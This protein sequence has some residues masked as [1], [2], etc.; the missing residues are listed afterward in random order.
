[1]PRKNTRNYTFYH[2]QE[3]LSE[4]P[5]IAPLSKKH[6]LYLNDETNDI[7]VFGGAAGSGKSQLSLM[8]ILQAALYDSDYVA[9]ILRKSQRMVKGAGSLWETGNKLFKPHG[10]TSNSIEMNW[11]FPSGSFVKAHYLNNNTDDMQG[12]QVTEW[13]VDEAAQC[14]ESDVW[15]LTSRLRSQSDRKHQLRLTCNPDRDSFLCEWLQKG[16]Y[17]LES[18]LPD[19]DMD[20]VTTYMLQINGNFEFYRTK[21]EIK[22]LY[23]TEA[24]KH[25]LSFVFYAAN[26]YDN[27]YMVKHQPDYV[28][29][30]ENMKRLERERL[31]LGNWYATQ[32][33]EGFLRRDHFKEVSLSE[34][35]LDAPTMRCWDI[36][37]TLPSES[38]PDPDWTRGIK[39]SYDK[40]SG[41]FYILDMESMRDRAAHVEKL[42]LDTARRDGR[43][44][45]QGIPQDAGA[46]GKQVAQSKKARLLAQ[47]NRAVIC[48][49]R[50]SKLNRAQDFM[51][52][53]QEGSVFV[54]KGVFSS[55]NYR[56]LEAFDGNKN[57]GAHDDIIDTLSDCYNQ[58]TKG[59]LISPIRVSKDNK[60]LQS[61]G[62]STLL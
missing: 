48:K 41:C 44:V 10:V 26:I 56:E 59:N 19:P 12:T 23:G 3:S 31:L 30:L 45:Y 4:I 27:P 37:G 58:L 40:E 50:T 33:S 54:V 46:T 15:Y 39:C 38:Y 20:G 55:D 57:S 22:A 18:G 28:F 62:G 34:V 14:D 24:Q 5:I 9:G 7:I 60:R 16:G 11:R 61:L 43:D 29:K 6:E 49:T 47:G 17:L 51:I 32:G 21:E 42:M 8:R 52:A 53:A 2:N 1:M 35:P 25:A 13:L 36:A